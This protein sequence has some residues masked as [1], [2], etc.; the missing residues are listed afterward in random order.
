MSHSWEAQ[1]VQFLVRAGM[2]TEARNEVGIGTRCTEEN[3]RS[4]GDEF[5]Q[6]DYSK[7]LHYT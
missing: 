4:V 6:C 3:Q 7:T 5:T 2:K 1:L